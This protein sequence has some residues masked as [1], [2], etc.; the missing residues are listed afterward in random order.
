MRMSLGRLARAGSSR[1]GDSD[2]MKI[3]SLPFDF[4]CG[5][6]PPGSPGHEKASPDVVQGPLSSCAL[7]GAIVCTSD[8]AVALDIVHLGKHQPSP[9]R[10][11]ARP[12]VA[13]PAC[14]AVAGRANPGCGFAR[15]RMDI[16]ARLCHVAKTKV[17]LS[18]PGIFCLT[19]NIVATFLAFVRHP[20]VDRERDRE[21]PINDDLGHKMVFLAGPRQVGKTTLAKHELDRWRSGT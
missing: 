3:E 7:N 5:G 2:A 1:D 21:A 19:A 8:T 6:R 16:H 10:A 14:G 15:T 13:S 4:Q 9:R 12:I 11:P 17:A 20:P 18:I